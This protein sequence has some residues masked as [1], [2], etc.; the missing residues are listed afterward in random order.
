M[1]AAQAPWY[2]E[3]AVLPLACSWSAPLGFSGVLKAVQAGLFQ[4]HT[5]QARTGESLQAIVDLDAEVFRR[6]HAV[7]K[8]GHL[9]IQ[10]FVVKRFEHFALD[11][12][13]ELAQVRDHPG[14]S[15]HGSR[16]GDLHHVVVAVAVRIVA[17]PV[18]PPVLLLTESRAVQPVR[19]R[20]RVAAREMDLHGATPSP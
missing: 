9:F 7:A 6:G 4:A 15:L 1:R 19:G 2:R 14:R 5:L 18:G 20:K 13:V 12:A 10:I 11:V 17:L 8:R 3:S 16:D